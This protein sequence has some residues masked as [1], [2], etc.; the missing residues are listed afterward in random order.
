MTWSLK[1][2]RVVEV[3][4]RA[5]A[6]VSRFQSED[7]RW[8]ILWGLFFIAAL[9]ISRVP[10]APRHL[11]TFD[12]INFALSIE[13]FDPAAHQ[14]QPPG[15]PLFVGLIKLL[16]LFVPK[17]ET[18]FLAAALLLSIA[19]LA[20]LWIL[21][22]ELLGKRWGVVPPLL[23]LWNPP[24]CG[25]LDMRIAADGTWHYLRTPI[26]RPALRMR[27]RQRS[28]AMIGAGYVPPGVAKVALPQQ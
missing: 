24:F 3:H 28:C 25:D 16:S 13:K 8:R 10:L 15:Y 19:A 17:V 4:S 22:E 21:G 12:E 2:V 14:P 1:P 7:R 9:L 11:I 18:V 26:G 20:L 6:D 27:V 5:A 23:L